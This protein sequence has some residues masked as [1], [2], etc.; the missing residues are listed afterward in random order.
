MELFFADLLN[1]LFTTLIPLILQMILGALF[2][3]TGA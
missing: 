2:G 3:G 1:A